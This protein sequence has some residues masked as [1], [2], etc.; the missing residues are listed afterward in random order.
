MVGFSRYRNKGGRRL[1][2]SERKKG[3]G[4][5]NREGELGVSALVVDGE[6]EALLREEVLEGFCTT[7]SRPLAAAHTRPKFVEELDGRAQFPQLDHSTYTAPHH[8]NGDT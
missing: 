5:R 6:L 8:W 1:R 2:V 3:F 4:L 7:S